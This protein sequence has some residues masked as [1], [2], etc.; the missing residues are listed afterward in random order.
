MK[1]CPECDSVFPDFNRFCDLDG[2]PLVEEETSDPPEEN[3]APSSS[4]KLLA[5]GAVAGL[6]LGVVLFVIYYALTRR[7]QP[8]VARVSTN[9]SVIPQPPPLLRAEPISNPSPSPS[10]SP[11]PSPTASPSPSPKPSPPVKLS[12]SPVSTGTAPQKVTIRLRNGASI[13]ADE[14]WEGK[15]G[16][17]YRQRGVVALLDPAQIKSIDRPAPEPSPSP[18]PSASASPQ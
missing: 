3:A 14:A 5:M 6:A 15:E 13:D 18:S 8:Q 17:W 9:A 4:W 7:E 11:S 1:R 2:T 16:I 10:A 12:S